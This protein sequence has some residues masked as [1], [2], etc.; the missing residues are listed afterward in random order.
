MMRRLRFPRAANGPQQQSLGLVMS[1]VVVLEVAALLMSSS[2]MMAEAVSTCSAACAKTLFDSSTAKICDQVEISVTCKSTGSIYGG[3]IFSWDSDI[4]VAAFWAGYCSGPN[5]I[6][7]KNTPVTLYLYWTGNRTSFH[8]AKRLST[9]VTTK[10]KQNDF[11]VL[12]TDEVACPSWL[13]PITGGNMNK[14]VNIIRNGLQLDFD[15]GAVYGSNYYA[16]GTYV[17]RAAAH[18]ALADSDAKM[19]LGGNSVFMYSTGVSRRVYTPSRGKDWASTKWSA[20]VAS[21]DA[22]GLDGF[23]F[24]DSSGP[25]APTAA[26]SGSNSSTATGHFGIDTAVQPI[27]VDWSWSMPPS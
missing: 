3:D 1:L 22:S 15:F 26:A 14:Q 17:H 21:S 11:G 23:T 5:P 19:A 2:S 24:G 9:S 13:S 7:P 25:F 18:M 6:N 27:W 16:Y 4:Q 8:R 10:G 12:V 20:A